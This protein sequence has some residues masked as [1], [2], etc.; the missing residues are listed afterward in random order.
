MDDPAPDLSGLGCIEV[1]RISVPGGRAHV[2]VAERDVP[3]P[4]HL[5]ALL[6][7]VERARRDSFVDAHDADHYTRSHLAL[8]LVVADL[9][10][11]DPDELEFEADP[12][13]MCGGPHG[14]P[15]IAGRDDLAVS[16]SHSAPWVMVG[17]SRHAIGVDVEVVASLETADSVVE[18]LH[19]AERSLVRA[20]SSGRAESFTRMWCR[21]EAY[22][23]ALG[24]GLARDTTADDLTQ[25]PPGWLLVDVVLPVEGVAAAAAAALTPVSTG[26]R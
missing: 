25:D 5:T 21:K 23:K 24:L 6:S 2:L 19:P 17:A 10:G 4:E 11:V 3:V 18:Q 1:A 13:P 9:L 14:R 7:D 20:S 12:C 16:L 8:R 15:R 26:A 22:L